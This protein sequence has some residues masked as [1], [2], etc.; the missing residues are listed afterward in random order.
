MNGDEQLKTCEEHIK[1]F[2]HIQRNL[3]NYYHA[4]IL[5]SHHDNT[6][7]QVRERNY[8]ITQDPYGGGE[9]SW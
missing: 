8:T 3:N 1:I 4:L 5:N 2:K 7:K 9:D 6:K